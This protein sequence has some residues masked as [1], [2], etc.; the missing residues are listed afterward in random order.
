MNHSKAALHGGSICATGKEKKKFRMLVFVAE[1]IPS[2]MDNV[3]RDCL[4]RMALL[5]L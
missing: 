4:G 3:L 2:G 5:L 1:P